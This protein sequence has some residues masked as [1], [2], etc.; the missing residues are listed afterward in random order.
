MFFTSL[1]PSKTAY[2]VLTHVK[3]IIFGILKKGGPPQPYK[4]GG[5]PL[6]PNR[7]VA[8]AA[9]PNKRDGSHDRP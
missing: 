2:V 6:P 1:F 4:E 7:G 9:T 8:H 3:Q 5:H